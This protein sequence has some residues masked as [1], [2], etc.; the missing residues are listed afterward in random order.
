MKTK[1][2]RLLAATLALMLCACD[3]LQVLMRE[4]RRLK[5]EIAKSKAGS[6]EEKHLQAELD[7]VRKAEMREQTANAELL[8]D[9]ARDPSEDR[10]RT[11]MYPGAGTM[12]HVP[13]P[14]PGITTTVCPPTPMR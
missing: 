3:N 8:A 11:N 6:A 9:L 2:L 5:H 4:E 14:Q 7:K 12:M 1:M 13:G 10:A